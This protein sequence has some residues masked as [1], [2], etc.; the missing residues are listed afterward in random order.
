MQ[1]T[2]Y[3]EINCYY[4]YEYS[5]LINEIDD[6]LRKCNFIRFVTETIKDD[7]RSTIYRNVFNIKKNYKLIL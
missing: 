2:I 4:I 3:T 5:F 6:Y 7:I 1:G